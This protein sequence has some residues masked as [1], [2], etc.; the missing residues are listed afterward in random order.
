MVDLP[1]IY[2]FTLYRPT[3]ALS[4]DLSSTAISL[5]SLPPSLSTRPLTLIPPAV[6]HHYVPVPVPVAAPQAKAVEIN[7]ITALV[8]T[9]LN[10]L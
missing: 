1:I 7:D 3:L 4:S 6:L 5:L 9:F 10:A 2:P 8:I